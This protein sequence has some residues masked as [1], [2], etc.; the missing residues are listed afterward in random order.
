MNTASRAL[1]LLTALA[2]AGF[3]QAEAK[4]NGGTTTIVAPTGPVTVNWG[5][6]A[7]V[8]NAAEYEVQIADLDRDGDGRI[9]R[10]E[11]EPNGAL[12]SEFKLVD[13]NRDGF[14]TATEL[15]NWK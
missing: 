1:C 11:A 4:S 10:G 6:A 9:S 15:A 12:S 3:A 7:T 13:R 8:P 14:V 2:G 5:Q